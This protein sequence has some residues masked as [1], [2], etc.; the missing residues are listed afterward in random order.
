MAAL[1][2]YAQGIILDGIAYGRGSQF[3]Y[4]EHQHE[5]GIDR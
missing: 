3:A 1:S 5:R 2:R 4:Q